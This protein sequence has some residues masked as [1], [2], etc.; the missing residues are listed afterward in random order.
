MPYEN[1]KIPEGIN[2]SKEHPIKEFAWLLSG[3]AILL[4]IIV[5]LMDWFGSSVARLIPFEA[6]LKL[7]QQ[8]DPPENPNDEVY[9]YLNALQQNITKAMNLDDSFRI[10]LRYN[11]GDTVNA[12]ATMGG[13]VILYRGLLKELPHENALV[14]LMAHEIAHVQHRDPMVGLGRGV[15]IQMGLAAVFGKTPQLDSVLG[16]AGMLQAMRYS[17][18]METAADEAALKAVAKIYGHV[19]GSTDLFKIL[20]QLR[21]EKEAKE[22]P[23][24]FST[25]PLDQNRINRIE[26]LAKKNQWALNG[27]TT[28]LPAL[29]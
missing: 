29:F 16:P 15:L 21:D 25:H 24:F 9:L 12:F 19:S 6:E 23:E 27:S 28:P 4:L 8:F 18:K 7:S 13:N 3:A 5:T 2:T 20:H 10:L 1:P 26:K 17:R 14:M 22:P 11:K